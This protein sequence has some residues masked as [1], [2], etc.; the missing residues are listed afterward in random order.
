MH[1]YADYS[2]L[3]ITQLVWFGVRRVTFN[4]RSWIKCRTFYELS[5]QWYK[6][7]ELR[8]SVYKYW[9][10]TL[11]LVHCV[12]SESFLTISLLILGLVLIWTYIIHL[13]IQIQIVIRVCI[14]FN[15]VHDDMCVLLAHIILHYLFHLQRLHHVVQALTRSFLTY[16]VVL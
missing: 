9:P 1:T 13:S 11:W 16:F 4:I 5:P 14:T 10:I 3:Y 12:T 7:D 6:S 15:V 8:T 2:A